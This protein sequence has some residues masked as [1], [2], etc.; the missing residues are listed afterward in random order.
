MSS[1]RIG[2]AGV[3]AVAVTYGFARYG[4]GL[5]A[6]R[7]GAAFDLSVT[8]VGVI[9]SAPYAAYLLALPLAGALSAR[10][11]PRAPVVTGGLAAAGGMALMALARTPAVL[12]AGLALAGTAPAWSW[13]PFSDAV[14]RA[15]PARARDRVLALIPSGTAFGVAVAGPTALLAGPHW[16]LA[17]LAFTA[18]ALLSTAYNA[19]TLPT[20]P[21]T[22]ARE[23]AVRPR[24]GAAGAVRAYVRAGSGR[25]YLTAFAYGLVGTGYWTFA[26]VLV[27]RASGGSTVVMAGAWTLMGV[28]GTAAVF[29]GAVLARIGLR[30]AHALLF[31]ALA[32]AAALLGAAPGVPAAI[33]ASVVLYGAAFMAVS[34]LL[35]VWSYRLFPDRPAAAFSVTVLFLGA[36]SVPGPAVLGAVAD[37]LGLPAV[38][39]ATAA[40]AVLTIGSR[41]ARNGPAGTGTPESPAPAVTCGDRLALCCTT[42]PGRASLSPGH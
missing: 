32:A 26:A 39:W 10:L 25:L 7:I 14:A 40:V 19:T 37:G 17:W 13:A 6:P 11:G 15:V 30:A 21:A 29:A 23:D 18:A 4:Y 34:G 3:T 31:A 8:M 42:N 33:A 20:G 22:P 38:F 36:G 28:A 12:A 24:R 5:F 35:A 2:F 27:G 9:A 41:P 16:R 1:V